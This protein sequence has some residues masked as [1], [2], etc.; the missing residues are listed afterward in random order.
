VRKLL[1]CP[2]CGGTDLDYEAGSITGQKY[3][4]PRCGYVGSFV[5]QRDL[6]E[7]AREAEDVERG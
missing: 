4:C 5:I 3:R 1:L 6:D 7:L 2:D